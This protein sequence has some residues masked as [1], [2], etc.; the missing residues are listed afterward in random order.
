MAVDLIASD[1]TTVSAHGSVAERLLANDMNPGALRT[2]AVL[3]KDEWEQ[4]DAAVVEIA[5]ERLN[6]VGDLVSRGLTYEVGN[7]MGTTIVQHE[8]VSEMTKAQI[9]MDGVTRGE[10]DR[11]TFSLVSTPLPVIHHDFQIS[12]RV[13]A[14]SR[15]SGSPLDTTQVEEATRQVAETTEEMLLNGVSDGDSKVLGFGSSAAT[16]FGYT[17]R[18]GRNTVSLGAEW[19]IA[20]TTGE[21]I[22]ADVL[23]MVTAAQVD[24]MFGPYFLYIP[25]NYW[26]KLQ[27]DYK[28]NSDKTIMQRVLEISGIEGVRPAD[29]LA[30]SN[31]LLVQMTKSNVDMV[32]GM[33]P[34]T[35]QWETQGGMMMM[36]KVMSIMVPRIKLDHNNRSGIVHAKV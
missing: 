34:T 18:T 17:D 15:Q 28:P 19:N 21:D 33:Q 9:T 3:R 27:D 10:N 16:I 30:D 1:G 35:V 11:V 29:K 20:A 26:V 14:A 7:G 36:F 2:N 23:A 8:T 6:A 24:R 12:A 13:L 32:I 31:V 25:S 22:M 4:L 5:R